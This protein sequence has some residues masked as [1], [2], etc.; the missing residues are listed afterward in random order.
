MERKQDTD[1][2]NSSCKRNSNEDRSI[3]NTSQDRKGDPRD[4]EEKNGGELPGDHCSDT[5][6]GQGPRLSS[7]VL[8]R[9]GIG[10]GSF[11][12]GQ[13]FAGFTMNT[14]DSAA[15]GGLEPRQEQR[16]EGGRAGEPGNGSK[17]NDD[18]SDRRKDGVASESPS[19]SSCGVANVPPSF[20]CPI[21]MDIMVDPVILATGHT[22]DRQSIEYWI[23]QGN[24]TCPVTGMKLRHTEMTPNFALRSAIQEWAG[25]HGIVLPDPTSR[26]RE[27]NCVTTVCQDNVIVRDEEG[28]EDQGVVLSGHDEIVWAL[29]Q[30]GDCL[31]TASADC[32]VRVWDIPSRRCIYVLEDHTRPVLSLA[33]TDSYIFSGSYDHSINVWS[34]ANFRKIATLKGHTDAVRALITCPRGPH[35]HMGYV[36]SGSYDGTLRLWEVGS[37]DC[38]AV[39]RGHTGPV[40]V[41]TECRG[42][43][44]SGSYDGTIRAWDMQQLKCLAVLKGHTSAVRALTSIGSYVCSGSD[45][46]T[47]RVWDAESLTCLAVLRGHEDNV[48]VLSATEDFVCSGSWDKTIRVWRVPGFECAAVLQGHTEAVLAL[49]A[50]KDYVVS[51]SYDGHVRVWDTDTW[52]CTRCFDKHADAVRVLASSGDK[53]FSGSYDGG[54]GII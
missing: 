24:K 4:G 13:E 46:A 12:L 11:E 51:G 14:V 48:R 5:S 41:L 2:N 15:V 8:Q 34:W 50:E 33:A 30:H 54:V 31:V 26:Q 47:V 49:T 10:S 52:S 45:D 16:H 32:T 3:I 37:W 18:H 29:Q 23:Q 43:I 27:D 6:N 39:L 40:R 36:C 21:G 53:I 19:P 38:V 17:L 1:N 44:F 20:V 7:H 42:V 22:Y 9:P 25:E 35:P 28:E